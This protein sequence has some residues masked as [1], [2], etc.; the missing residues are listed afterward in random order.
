MAGQITTMNELKTALEELE[1]L[2][3]R[4][5]KP[6]ARQMG[7]QEIQVDGKTVVVRLTLQ[8]DGDIEV[9]VVS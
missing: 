8:S 2:S 9:Q 6:S 4:T 7:T 5:S 3:A 1:E